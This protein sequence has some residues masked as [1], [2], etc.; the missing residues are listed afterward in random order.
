[1][2]NTFSAIAFEHA[3]EQINMVVKGDGGVIG[4]TENASQLLRCMVSGPE[5]ARAVNEYELQQELIKH[6]QN[7]GPDVRLYEQVE[8]K[9]KAFLKQVITLTATIEEM[10]KSFLEESED[11]SV[12]D[13]RDIINPKVANTVRNIEEIEGMISL[14]ST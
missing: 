8:S 5:K 13:T 12:L 11:L 3:Y 14:M 7:K 4:L 2:H 10:G 1:M 9:Q 6:E